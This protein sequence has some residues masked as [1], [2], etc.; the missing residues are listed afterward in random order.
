MPN[1]PLI[2]PFVNTFFQKIKSFFN[3]LFYPLY[4]VVCMNSDHMEILITM[5]NPRYDTGRYHPIRRPEYDLPLC[6]ATLR[7]IFSA[8][9][10]FQIREIAFGM[11]GNISLTVCWL[12]G[13]VSGGD[14]SCNILRPLTQSARTANAQDEAQAK[15]AIEHGGVYSCSVKECTETD[16]LITALTHG[17]CAVVFDALQTALCFEVKSDKARAV[18]EPTLEKALKGAKDSFVETLRVNTALVRRRIASPKLKLMECT[19]GRKSATRVAVM[20]VDGVAAPETVEAVAARLAALDVDGLVAVGILEEGLVDAPASSFPQLAHTERPDRFA[21]YLLDGRVGILVDGI[22]VGL[23]LPVTFAEFMKVTSDTTSH[24]LVASAVAVLR[25]FSLALS[26]LLPALYVAIAMYHQEMIPSRLLLSIIEAKQDV[27]FSTALEVIG[28]LV[29]FTLLQEAGL[30]LPN[31]IG[32]TVSIIGALIVGQSA[33]EARVVSPI[34]IIVVALSGIAGYTLPSQDMGS[35][36]RL[37]RFVLV[38]AAIAAGL[39]GVTAVMCLIIFSLAR[40]DSF[41]VNY[42]APLSEGERG[43]FLKLFARMPKLR[44]KY[45]DPLLNTPDRRRQK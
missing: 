38:I 37:V 40:I 34:A 29:S 11:E 4:V 39:F 2:S 24:F 28:M 27:P 35:A 12:D 7:E 43:A 41:G 1:I 45:R 26:A 16:A 33:V 32:D 9:A 10:D 19:I 22:P 23:I 18:S 36:V 30:R 8:C 6:S 5:F 17:H 20:F 15:Y 3:F 14:V 44:D 31:P 42:T 25:Y 21:M 13:I